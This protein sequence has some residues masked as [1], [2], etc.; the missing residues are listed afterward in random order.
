MPPLGQRRPTRP[1]RLAVLLLIA[2]LGPA[3]GLFPGP[4]AALPASAIADDPRPVGQWPLDPVPEVVAGFDPPTSTWGA[5]HRGVDLLGAVGRPV[6]TAL[7][8]RITFAGRLAGRGV[9]VVDHGDT[10]TT[11]EP[12]TA[13]VGLGDLVSAGD[14]IGTLELPGSHCF[15][16]VCLHWGWL[17][18]DTYLD[19]LLLVGAGPVRLLPLWRDEPVATPDGTLERL[20]AVPSLPYAAWRPMVA[21][22]VG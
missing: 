16:R 2:L 9:V 3:P 8:G 10:R 1:T 15:P 5:G 17:R 4:L 22:W 20:P 11:Y 19:P 6:R 18:G 12:V 13:R 7:P 21:G 14:P